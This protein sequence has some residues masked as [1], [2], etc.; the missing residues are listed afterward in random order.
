MSREEK[1]LVDGAVQRVLESSRWILGDEVTGFEQEFARYVGAPEVVG[2]GNGTDALALAFL[3]LEIPPGSEVIVCETD[4]GYGA[5]AARMVG[6]TPVPMEVDPHSFVPTAELAA[7]ALSSRTRA[8]VVTH[9]H[10]TAVPLL[11]LDQWR[12]GAGLH[13]IEDCAHAH[14]LRVDGNH[15]G[16]TG[17]IATFSF[18]PT[19]NLGAVGDAGALVFSIV[20]RVHTTARSIGTRPSSWR[21]V[22]PSSISATTTS[23]CR[24]TSTI[25]SFS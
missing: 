17:D 5:V 16:T 1:L 14:G 9:L 4:G 20:P 7:Q 24:T 19:K 3:A 10:G 18:Y 8:V 23:S 2:V 21:G 12:H 22:T 6:L 15:V 11:E 13:M 25:F